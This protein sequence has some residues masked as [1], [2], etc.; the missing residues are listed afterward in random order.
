M[1]QHEKSWIIFLSILGVIAPFFYGCATEYSKALG[2]TEVI[3]IKDDS[4]VRMGGSLAKKLEKKL[5]LSEDDLLQQRV[6]RIGQEIASVCD[7][8]DIQ[9]H[10]KVLEGK[11][12][13]ALSLPGGYIYVHEG[14][15]DKVDTND[16]LAF[17]L[18]HEIGHVAAKHSV[19]RIQ[20]VLGYTLLRVLTSRVKGSREVGEVTDI[21]FSQIMLGYSR[22]DELL[23]DRLA[24]RYLQR[25]GYD[26]NG[27]V[28]FLKKLREIE[29]KKPARPPN[30]IKTHPP[31]SVR[32]ET[33]NAEIAGGIS[34]EDYIGSLGEPY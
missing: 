8:K 31:I 20:G 13:N 32:I 19:K 12:V 27:G 9:Y 33:V 11:D 24:V 18:A 28:V 16:E 4:E 5:K 17:V 30:Y 34:F 10:F 23:A 3:L 14:L 25:A 15:I 22:E 21:A 2:K 1:Q 6:D 7:R 29:R 26:P